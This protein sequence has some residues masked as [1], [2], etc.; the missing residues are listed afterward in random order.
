MFCSNLDFRMH[1]VLCALKVQIRWS[2]IPFFFNKVSTENSK[3]CH[4]TDSSVPSFLSLRFT[5]ETDA[6]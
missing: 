1:F 6:G 5:L 2:T 4:D 3:G